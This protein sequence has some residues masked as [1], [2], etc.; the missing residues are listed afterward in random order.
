MLADTAGPFVADSI[1]AILERPGGMI[2]GIRSVLA[3]ITRLSSW[4]RA[5]ARKDAADAIAMGEIN[6]GG[7][8]YDPTESS[9]AAASDS[10]G[11]ILTA[12]TPRAT[13]GIRHTLTIEVTT[14]ATRVGVG[15]IGATAGNNGQPLHGRER[16]D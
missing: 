3:G 1:A 15:G 12:T 8:T 4:L 10:R 6:T 2:D 13:N 7:G 5:L 11:A 9:L 16:R 14:G